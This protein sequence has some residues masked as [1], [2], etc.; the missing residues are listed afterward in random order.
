MLGEVPLSMG[1]NSSSPGRG[2]G[3]GLKADLKESPLQGT[4]TATEQAL[5]WTALHLGASS[6]VVGF[7][8]GIKALQI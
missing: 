8:D 2:E 1:H 3:T 6:I 7:L 5:S 4:P